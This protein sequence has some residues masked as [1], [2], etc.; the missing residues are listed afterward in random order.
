MREVILEALRGA[1][2]RGGLK[3]HFRRELRK[4][5]E[6]ERV[7]VSRPLLKFLIKIEPASWKKTSATK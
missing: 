1:S 2:I 4:E 6:G 3:V 5:L 7:E